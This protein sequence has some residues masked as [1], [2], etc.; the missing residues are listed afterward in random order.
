MFIYF[1]KANLISF[2]KSFRDKRYILCKDLL[3][4]ERNKIVINSSKKD[5]E[6]CPVISEWIKTM[7]EDRESEISF[8]GTIFPARPIKGN[9]YNAFNPSNY[10][11]AYLIDD[12]GSDKISKKGCL[13]FEGVGK[14]LDTLCQ[15]FYGRYQFTKNID[16]RE[17]KNWS[18]LKEYSMPLTDIIIVDQFCL[19]SPEITEYNIVQLLKGLSFNVKNTVINI[20]IFTAKE[21]FHSTDAKEQIKRELKRSI[22]CA[23]N[24]TIVLASKSNLKEHDRNVITNYQT[25][26]SG[27]SFNYFN[28]KYER[29]TKGRNLHIKSKANSDI[30]KSANSLIQD[31]QTLINSLDNED[32]FIGDKKSNYLIFKS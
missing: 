9:T 15:L 28:S 5:L 24:V 8:S 14:E 3:Q 6:Q 20:V 30:E 12:S 26:D 4:Y 29:I 23:P 18:F 31:M 10:S 21:S 22:G 13:L 11:S 32:L 16:V 27:D 2:I 19:S 1:D 17:L 25:L 7:T